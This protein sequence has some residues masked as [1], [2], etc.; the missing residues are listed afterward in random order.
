MRRFILRSKRP[1][2]NEGEIFPFPNQYYL[3]GEH[4]VYLFQPDGLG[5]ERDLQFADTLHGTFLKTVSTKVTYPDFTATLLIT[6]GTGGWLYPGIPTRANWSLY[7]AYDVY[8]ELITFI[9]DAE[10]FGLYLGYQSNGRNYRDD[11]YSNTSV[12]PDNDADS[13][14]YY[15]KIKFKSI[16]K[17]E[18]DVYGNLQC[19]IVFSRLTPWRRWNVPAIPTSH[20]EKTRIA[21]LYPPNGIPACSGVFFDLTLDASSLSNCDRLRLSVVKKKGLNSDGTPYGEPIWTINI[22]PS[23][24]TNSILIETFEYSCNPEDCYIKVNGSNYIDYMDISQNLFPKDLPTD[25]ASEEYFVYLFLGLP[26]TGDYDAVKCT[27][28][29]Y[30]YYGSV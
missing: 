27:V 6:S 30:L 7:S 16:S 24:Y 18:L 21:W 23:N 9:Q 22:G 12:F 28:S 10:K 13:N 3:N 14:F 19:K 5:T 26:T 1:D 17:T 15:S 25:F 2:P 11:P 20:W 8:N 4:G 29:E